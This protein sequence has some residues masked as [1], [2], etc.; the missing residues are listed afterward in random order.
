MKPWQSTVS[1]AKAPSK[2]LL[3]TFDT[4][5]LFERSRHVFTLQ[6][7]ASRNVNSLRNWIAG[8]GNIQ[9]Q[10]TTYLNKR[11]D[12]VNL[13]GCDDGAMERVGWFLEDLLAWFHNKVRIVSAPSAP[14]IPRL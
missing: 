3:M 11:D 2:R 10:E 4:D 9:R 13:V 7:A 14:P 8:T 6:K 5:A 12:L 1:E